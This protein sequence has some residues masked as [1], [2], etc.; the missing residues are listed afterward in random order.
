[1]FANLF[2]SMRFAMQRAAFSAVAGILML[3]GLAFLTAAAWIGLATAYS[4]LVAAL[5]IGCVYMGLGFVLLAMASLRRPLPPPVAPAV[6]PAAPVGFTAAGLL[7]AFVQG[8]G[9]GIAASAAIPKKTPPP[10]PP[11]P[12]PPQGG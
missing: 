3:V 11:P 6:P 9:A 7:G 12:P 2:L 1:M 5:V 8:I 4:T 10:P